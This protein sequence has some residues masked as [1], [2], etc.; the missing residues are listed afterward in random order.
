PE[1]RATSRLARR[2]PGRRR[3]GLRPR[4]RGRLPLAQPVH[5]DAEGNPARPPGLS[6]RDAPAAR[7]GNPPDPLRDRR[8][9]AVHAGTA[10]PPVP[11]EPRAH[12]PA[13]APGDPEAQAA[14]RPGGAEGCAGEALLA[15]LAPCAASHEPELTGARGLPSVE[16]H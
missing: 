9:D 4:A 13:G 7:A 11:S 12:P 2:A 16:D 10:G 5:V 14:G 3:A 15:P 8:P 6:A 1:V